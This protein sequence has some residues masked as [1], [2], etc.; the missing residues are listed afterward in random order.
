MLFMEL[1]M[2]EMMKIPSPYFWAHKKC[3]EVVNIPACVPGSC[4][5]PLSQ[6]CFAPPSIFRPD[7]PAHACQ[8]GALT[9]AEAGFPALGTMWA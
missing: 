9:P 6:A 4:G 5:L 2:S 8:D 1:F 3:G 7:S